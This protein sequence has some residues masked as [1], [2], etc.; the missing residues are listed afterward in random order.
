MSEVIKTVLTADS[1]DLR[2]EFGKATA[3]LS[4]YQKSQQDGFA[5]TVRGHEQELAALRLQKDGFT[6]LAAS[7]RETHA[8][9][10]AAVRMA[11]SGNITEEKALALLREKQTLQKQIAASA[12]QAA[13]ASS[14]AIAN[15]RATGLPGGGGLAPLTP[16]SLQAM[17]R[18]IAQTRELGRQTNYAGQAGKNG[19][20]GFLAFSQAVEDAQYGVKGILNNIPQM[21][22]G[23]GG[24]AGLAGVL[25]LAAVAGYAAWQAF[26]KLSGTAKMVEWAKTSTSAV[27]AMTQSIR[28]NA[29]ETLK[30]QAARESLAAVDEARGKGEREIDRQVGVDS[31]KY[32]QLAD[33]A[34]ATKRARAAED[35]NKAATAAALE[36]ARTLR[37]EI[38]DANLLNTGLTAAQRAEREISEITFSDGKR[39]FTKSEL[40]SIQD[41]TDGYV[42]NEPTPAQLA[43][44]EKAIIKEDGKRQFDQAEAKYIQ[45]KTRAT[46]D[47]ATAQQNLTTVQK[48]WEKTRESSGTIAADIQARRSEAA[49]AEEEARRLAAAREAEKAS[50]VKFLEA[51]K[52]GSKEARQA[53]A[54]VLA[55]EKEIAAQKRIQADQKNQVALQDELR[56]KNEDSTKSSL[57]ELDAKKAAI[58]S[59][60]EQLKEAGRTRD[61]LAKTEAEGIKQLTALQLQKAEAD[62]QALV[63]AK[64][65]AAAPARADVAAELEFMNLRRQGDTEKANALREEVAL[66]KEATA[67]AKALNISEAQALALIKERNLQQKDITDAVKGLAERQSDRQ[68][69]RDEA[70]QTAKEDSR[71]KHRFDDKLN[72][73]R[74]NEEKRRAKEREENA[75]N[76]PKDPGKK[77]GTSFEKMVTLQQEL[78]T[79]FKQLGIA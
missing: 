29:E 39:Q 61:E 5:K 79:Y 63:R 15:P 21:I 48:D 57:T 59:E 58:Q 42:S 1:S 65:W 7:L 14:R 72:V 13:A 66:R 70:R 45:E 71:L 46:Q 23:F 37:K 44:R 47:L 18:A 22:M 36:R 3:A 19:S 24:G 52:P 74:T 25:S 16:Q 75:K 30:L 2:A 4:G 76:L 54:K 11:A 28:A 68:A 33:E 43:E 53:D 41:I 73:P 38:T 9:R 40:K 34:A 64:D 49:A 78:V 56:R 27:D 32:Q 77:D 60:I 17:D 8:L 26:E 51:A 6:N 31:S 35:A 50:A 55:L 20:L 67:E 62:R 10:E 12:Q 69:A